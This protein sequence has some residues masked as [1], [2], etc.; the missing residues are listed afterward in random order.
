MAIDYDALFGGE[1][2][3]PCAALKALRPVYMQLRAEGGV[4]R[5]RFRDRD[6]EF[7]VADVEGLSS[8]I[9]QLESECAAKSGRRTRRAA[10]G[11]FRMAR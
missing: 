11:R 10:V 7:T 3:D 9:S 1:T 4:R 2:Y 6:T 8:L 5:V